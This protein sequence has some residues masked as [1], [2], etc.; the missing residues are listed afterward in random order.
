MF[1]LVILLSIAVRIINLM[2]KYIVYSRILYFVI[3]LYPGWSEL[4]GRGEYKHCLLKDCFA[5]DK[6]VYSISYNSL[7][8]KIGNRIKS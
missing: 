8:I 2:T 6:C 1:I 7:V 4:T 5:S 3:F